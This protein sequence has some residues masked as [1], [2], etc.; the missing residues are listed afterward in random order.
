MLQPNTNKR[1][2]QVKL[3]KIPKREK[4]SP[5]ESETTYQF[6]GKYERSQ[7]WLDLDP[8]WIEKYL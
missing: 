4:T 1:H 5:K 8:D 2:I 3:L 7:H 6:Y